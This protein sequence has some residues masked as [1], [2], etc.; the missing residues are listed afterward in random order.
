MTT[1]DNVVEANPAETRNDQLWRG[2]SSLPFMDELFFGMQARN[3]VIVDAQLE[4]WELD[5]LRIHVQQERTP[6]VELMTLSAFSQL[7]IF[8][9][10]ELLRTWRQQARRIEKLAT[11]PEAAITKQNKVGQMP[12]DSGAGGIARD[13]SI[14]T[15]Y[16][17]TRAEMARDPVQLAVLMSAL[18]RVTIL[19]ER[20][21]NLRVTLAKHEI[22]KRNGVPSLSPGYARQDMTDGCLI[23][24]VYLAD[25]SMDLVSRTAIVEG[26][27]GFAPDRSPGQ[28]S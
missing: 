23:W 11:R 18:D 4:D 9:V 25:N 16:F 8:G 2:L 3:L 13:A 20:L 1:R 19:F 17:E 26:I 15:A 10:Y 6:I 22:P 21:E 27:I 24:P 28:A 5:V 12:K 7:W 14:G